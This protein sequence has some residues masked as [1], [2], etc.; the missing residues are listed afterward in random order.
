MYSCAVVTSIWRWDL[1]FGM[2]ITINNRFFVRKCGGLC[3]YFKF[4]SK[5]V[6]CKGCVQVKSRSTK[7]GDGGI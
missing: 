7:S 5:L 2:L 6:F 3:H 1:K 4:S